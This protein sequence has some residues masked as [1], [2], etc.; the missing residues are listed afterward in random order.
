MGMKIATRSPERLAVGGV[1]VQ[2]DARDV[3]PAADEPACPLRPARG[4]DDRVPRCRELDAEIVYD[5]GP[6]AVRLV[7]RD[8][9]ELGVPVRAEQP[10]QAGQVRLL[11]EVGR[12]SPDEVAHASLH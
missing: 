8:A 4:V 6:E 1:R 11:D 3:E 2:A 7:D 12:R 5:R 9:V 10:R